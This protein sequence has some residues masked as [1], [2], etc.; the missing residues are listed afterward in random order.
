MQKSFRAQV[1]AAAA[2]LALI[3]LS[4]MAPPALAE[5]AAAAT[6]VVAKVNGEAITEAD[7]R[8]A[9]AELG[10]DLGDLPAE[11]KRRAVA[12]Y[13]IDNV[14]FANAATSA[15]LD[16]S[17]EF[18]EQL[19]YL[20]R[21]LLR[22]QFFEKTLKGTVSED[23]AKKIYDARVAEMKPEDEFAA[24]HILVDNEAKAKELRDKIAAGADFAQLAKENSLDTGSKEQGGLLGYLTPAQLVPEFGDK[25]SK[26]Q[27]GELSEPIKT[28]FGWHVI[29]LEDRRRKAPPTFDSVKATIMNSLAVRKA[30]EKA[31]D[32]RSKASLEYVDEGI[33]KQIEEQKAKQ[34][35]AEA[36]KKAAPAG[37]PAGAPA[38]APEAKQPDAK[39]AD[40]PAPKQ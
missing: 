25:I 30:Q 13:L 27:K 12:E 36:A 9:E 31:A 21:R 22:E 8:I 14:L 29:K 40:A 1:S 34:A 11:V 3:L 4:V 33:K 39:P 17:P 35:E 5:D 38:A 37:A 16:A 2:G 10:A 7:M 23:E 28:Q 18:E 6:K 20:R 19:R 26:M 24:R 15:K 32:L